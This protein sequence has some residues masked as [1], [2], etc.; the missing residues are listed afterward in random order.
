[1]AA[2]S[3]I[4]S[5]PGS[6]P[7]PLALLADQ[8]ADTL[9]MYAEFLRRQGYEI[10]Q[11]IDGREALAK[12]IARPPQMIVTDIRLP[13]IGGV[14]LCRLLREDAATRHVPIL[15]LTSHRERAAMDAT[16]RMRDCE[17][18]DADR[19][20]AEFTAPASAGGR[21]SRPPALPA[22]R[23]EEA[24]ARRARARASALSH[25]IAADH[26]AVSRMPSLR[27]AAAVHVELRRRRQRDAARAVGSVHLLRRV[28]HFPVP[29]SHAAPPQH[30]L[31][32]TPRHLTRSRRVVVSRLLRLGC[33]GGRAWQ[34]SS[35]ATRP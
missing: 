28:R 33:T 26:A 3:I 17:W 18:D 9:D 25:D 21:A 20:Q 11:A 29:P 8:D 12:A 31:A 6:E 19:A 34:M 1:M 32:P 5:A 23:A 35:I 7:R 15:I 2:H 14:D 24:A 4:R 30:R 13:G 10:E 22:R 27:S 16:T